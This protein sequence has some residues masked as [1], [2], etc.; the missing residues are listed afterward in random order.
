MMTRGRMRSEHT[1]PHG[2][3]DRRVRIRRHKTPPV[4][5]EPL[6]PTLISVIREAMETRVP[7]ACRNN[8]GHFLD[9]CLMLCRESRQYVQREESAKYVL[10]YEQWRRRPPLHNNLFF[11]EMWP[12]FIPLDG[13]LE[14][15]AT[16]D[17]A[18]VRRLDVRAAVADRAGCIK[19]LE[20]ESTNLEVV[21]TRFFAPD[22]PA[23][24]PLGVGLFVGRARF[25]YRAIKEEHQDDEDLFLSC[26]VC[27]RESFFKRG[28]EEEDTDDDLDVA[29]PPL[30][31]P[32]SQREYWKLCGGRHPTL[33]PNS[34]CCCSSGCVKVI[35][36]EYNTAMAVT[37]DELVEFDA[38]AHKEGPGRIP[39]ALRAALRRNELVARRMRITEKHR[40]TVLTP[41]EVETA[42]RMC[43]K[44]LNT[45]LALLH[46]A[47]HLA[48]S[49]ALMAGRVIPPLTPNWRS[50]PTLCRSSAVGCRS[51]YEA[52]P[53][54]DALPVSTLV[55][56]PRFITK[57][58]DRAVSFF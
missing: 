21:K 14:G 49:P 44:M 23:Q 29:P 13:Q 40:Y 33:E 12:K 2:P 19:T 57:S 20:L 47:A 56:R 54:H 8:V 51:I 25:M 38:P 34:L 4:P 9:Q 17:R 26:R 6:V 35:Q 24:V 43:S 36:D 10:F 50:L 52:Y 15:N 16:S 48:E 11:L 18:A 22:L 28:V 46:A 55:V 30:G 39:A 45:D 37:A 27:G 3:T 7:T 1:P 31:T 32:C 41:N 58:R 53:M 42:R 5:W